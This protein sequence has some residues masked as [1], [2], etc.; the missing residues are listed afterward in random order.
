[1]GTPSAWRMKL[2]RVTHVRVNS[3]PAGLT[4]S[5][6]RLLQAVKLH[7]GGFRG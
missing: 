2:L 1:M 3:H 4:G 7:G 5:R 6:P